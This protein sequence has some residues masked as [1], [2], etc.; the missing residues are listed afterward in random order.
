MDAKITIRKYTPS[1]RAVLLQLFRLNTPRYFSITE[2]S[3]FIDYLEN[4]AGH[5][6]IVESG[7]AVVGCGGYNLFP[8]QA[9][10]R[11]SW[12]L[13]HPDFQGRGLGS[14]LLQYRIDRINEVP[15]LKTITVR[16]SQWVYR[17]Y[18]KFGFELKEV[19]KDYWAEGFDLY[20]MVRPL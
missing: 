19:I 1:H 4:H 11:I 3:H 16:T 18:E 9:D 8:E 14:A 17:F 10:A 5:F 15:G 12:D 13:F 2:E 20:R 6:F 7:G